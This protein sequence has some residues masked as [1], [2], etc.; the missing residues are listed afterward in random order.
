M[1]LNEILILGAVL[2][3]TGCTLFGLGI[4]KG[5]GPIIMGGFGIAVIGFITHLREIFN[6]DC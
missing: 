6:A 4:D 1:K 3:I 5:N 2:F